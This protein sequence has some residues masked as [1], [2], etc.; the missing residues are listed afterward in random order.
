MNAE[1]LKIGSFYAVKRG[2]RIVGGKLASVDDSEDKQV[3]TLKDRVGAP[4]MAS[5]DQLLWELD[6]SFDGARLDSPDAAPDKKAAKAA[7]A[8]KNKQERKDAK[9]R[10]KKNAAERKAKKKPAKSKPKKVLKR[11]PKAKSSGPR[12]TGERKP[13]NKIGDKSLREHGVAVLKRHKPKPLNCGT[14]IAELKE[15]GEWKSPNGKSPER[16]LYSALMRE[17][18][19]GK[20]S[21]VAWHEG[22]GWSYNADGAALAEAERKERSEQK[23]ANAKRPRKTKETAAKGE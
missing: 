6:G 5:P 16:T 8:A 12:K 1:N 23:K 20:T 10:M 9:E 14:I 7:I 4:L 2:R 11:K 13:S 17:L 15:K 3:L 21:A 22:G 18:A 19:K